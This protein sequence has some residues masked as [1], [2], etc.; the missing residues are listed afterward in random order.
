MQTAAGASLRA[1]PDPH[2]VS[3]RTEGAGGGGRFFEKQVYP[4]V[5]SDGGSELCDDLG[6]AVGGETGD[7]Q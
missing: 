1:V 2:T 4:D 5:P 7:E 3:E 6:D